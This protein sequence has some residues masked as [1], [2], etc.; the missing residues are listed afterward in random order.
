MELLRALIN[1]W[2]RDFKDDRLEFIV[3]QLADHLDR[4]GY[5][6]SKIQEQQLLAQDKIP[7]VRTVVC[8][9]VCDNIDIHPKEKDILSQRIVNLL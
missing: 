6:W 1:N 8:R 7:Y 5:A 2:R 3:I 4:A 9:D